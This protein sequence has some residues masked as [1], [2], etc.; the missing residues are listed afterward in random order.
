M[1]AARLL[2]RHRPTLGLLGAAALA[3]LGT[4]IQAQQIYRI[5]GPDG[6]VTF[7]DRAPDPSVTAKIISMGA[8]PSAGTANTVGLPFE[9]HQVALKF[10][11][12]LYTANNCEVCNQ[13]R[14][15]FTSRGIPF[16]EKTVHTQA[17]IDAFLKL[18]GDSPMPYA[19]IGTQKLKG[20]NEGEWNRFLSAAAYPEKSQLPA[21]YKYAAA[22][23]LVEPPK[24]PPAPAASTPAGNLP[25]P[26]ATTPLPSPAPN[27]PAGIRF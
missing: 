20:Y 12:V 15:L 2:K 9:L 1:N 16:A 18:S 24:D 23:P 14:S 4:S 10:P 5:V 8:G 7:T 25:P 6:R 21:G 27:N 26:S 3:L 11:V 22:A 19:T 13:A 17:D